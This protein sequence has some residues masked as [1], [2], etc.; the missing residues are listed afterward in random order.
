MKHQSK[1]ILF[2]TYWSYKDGLVQTAALPHI[3]IIKKYLHKDAKCYLLT[4]EQSRLK[5][6][7]NEMV[8]EK[9]K[10][11]N[12]G[13]YLKSANYYS[14]GFKAVFRWIFLLIQLL[15]ICFTRKITYIHAWCPPAGTIGYILSIFTGIPLVLD[16][17]EPHAQPML[18][19]G[20]WSKNSLAFRLLFK[21]EKLQSKRA[22]AVVACV[23]KMRNY[24]FEKY[25]IQLKKFY[26][27]HACVDFKKFSISNIKNHILIKE[28]GL[29]DKIVCVYAGKFGGSYLT[30]EFFD[31]FKV[32]F[33][34]W[35]NKFM[36]LLLTNHCKNELNEWIEKS[37]FPF[38]NII[39]KFVPHREVPNY[40]G[41]GDFAITPFK[42]VP[43]KRYGSP[44][45][46]G[47][48]WALGLP[49]VIT[50]GISNDSEIIEDNKIGSIIRNFTFEG[51]Y[52]SVK[53]IDEILINSDREELRNRIR[54]IAK[55]YRG[56]DVAEN[57]YKE[58]YG[59]NEKEIDGT[60]S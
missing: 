2:L 57:V 28:L 48:Y 23:D 9:K 35:G 39:I 24:A 22:I 49:V 11:A 50:Q 18:E 12:N 1:N 34:Y 37:A 19:S 4:L 16:S 51:Y 10:L 5:M 20:T 54:M 36:L 59:F 45:K 17:Y 15:W 7:D 33:D 56:F 46:T 42:P 29:Q 30:Q 60:E 8:D 14:F 53:E 40:M 3:R 27:K 38:E 31:F 58:I 55:K 52:N 21:F 32:A 26:V 47:E 13:I 43:S 6:T 44:I 25:G 41:L